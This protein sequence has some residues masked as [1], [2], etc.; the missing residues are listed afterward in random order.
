MQLHLFPPTP[1][2]NGPGCASRDTRKD[3]TS[4]EGW[5]ARKAWKCFKEKPL[6]IASPCYRPPDN[7]GHLT[8]AAPAPLAKCGLVVGI[9]GTPT[10]ETQT[11]DKR[12]CVLKGKASM[13]LNKNQKTLLLLPSAHCQIIRSSLINGTKAPAEQNYEK[14]LQQANP[15]QLF[16]PNFQCLDADEDG[17]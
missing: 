15:P 7:L 17:Q 8:T 6:T 11:A 3:S 4:T 13:T 10:Q 1:S 16:F 9:S 14:F 5:I 2:K 12:H